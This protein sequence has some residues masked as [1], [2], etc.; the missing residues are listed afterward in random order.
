[1]GYVTVLLLTNYKQSLNVSIA[2]INLQP[3][4]EG[5]IK[6]TNTYF[7]HILMWMLYRYIMVEKGAEPENFMIEGMSQR[8]M[9]GW[10]DRLIFSFHQ[11]F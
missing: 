11:S 2:F 1:M 6:N 10:M 3:T 7:L 5:T 9:D 4:F 8:W